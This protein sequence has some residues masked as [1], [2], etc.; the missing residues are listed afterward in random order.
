MG[1]MS[2]ASVLLFGLAMEQTTDYRSIQYFRALYLQPKPSMYHDTGLGPWLAFAGFAALL[3]LA[4]IVSSAVAQNTWLIVLAALGLI[5]QNVAGTLFAASL[6]PRSFAV[7]ELLGR[8]GGIVLGVKLVWDGHGVQGYLLGLAAASL[9]VGG[10]SLVIAWPRGDLSGGGGHASLRS[11]FGYGTPIALSAFAAWALLFVDRYLLAALKTTGAVGVY[12]VGAIIGD[13]AV[14]IPALAFFM[15]A[16]PLLITAF[17][18]RGRTEVERLMHEYT[19]VVLLITLPVLA[20]VIVAA[21]DVVSILTNGFYANYYVRAA[22]VAPVVALGAVFYMLALVGSTGL[23]V[24]RRSGQLLY[25]AAAALAANVAANLV[26]IPPFGIEGAAV[27]TPIG[28]AAF[29]LAAQRWAR[30]HATWRFPY[31]TLMRASAAT[32]V[33]ALAAAGLMLLPSSDLARVLIG[34]AGGGAAYALA[35]VVL[36]ERRLAFRSRAVR[37]ASG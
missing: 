15:A 1:L 20:F 9:A 30:H 19:R 18:Q 3:S 10:V 2:A 25:A 17:E 23:I 4:G 26:L 24:A 6:R 37:V 21:D 5:A 35:L 8:T 28:T 27:A 29:L 13:K 14:T 22:D 16:R 36:G 33:G 11:W 32:V 31:A 12:T 7:M 34:A